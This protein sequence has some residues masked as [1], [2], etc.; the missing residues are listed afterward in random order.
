MA[1]R[2]SG[3]NDFLGD[4]KG[5]QERMLPPQFPSE[6]HA[7]SPYKG[8]PRPMPFD[9]GR[10]HNLPLVPE[11]GPRVGLFQVLEGGINYDYI[12]CAGFDPHT[13]KYLERV[14]VAK[15]F[16]LQRTPFDGETVTLRDMQVTYEYLGQE[17]LRIARAVIDDDEVEELQR[18]TEDYFHTDILSVARSM[19]RRDSATGMTDDEGREIEWVDLNFSGRAWAVVPE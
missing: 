16:L 14:A 9:A 4:D 11:P 1:I 15:P 12:L 3:S 2:V 13:G 10:G 5:D 19:L 18:I 6:R 7:R 8:F 17:G